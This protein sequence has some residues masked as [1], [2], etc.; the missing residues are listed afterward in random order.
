MDASDL[1]EWIGV[2]QM[3]LA[4]DGQGG[5]IERVPGN[6]QAAIPASV[7]PESASDINTADQTASRVRFRVF[8]RYDPLVTTADRIYWPAGGLTLQAQ[9]LDI[10]ADPINVRS[11]YKW[12]Q[13][14][15]ERK[16]W[17]KQ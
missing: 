4:P 12:L 16:E 3:E 15:C 10:I 11:E 5:F 9:L 2:F 8:M 14:R 17:G 6:L 13:M 1:T 7:I